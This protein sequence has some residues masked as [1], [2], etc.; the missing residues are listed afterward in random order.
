MHVGVSTF[1]PKPHTPFQWVGQ[2]SR[3]VIARHQDILRRESR[4]HGL[5][6]S[7]NEY[8]SSEV[9][10]VLSRGDRRI[11]NVIQRAWEQGARFDGW[12]EC[13]RHDLWM[14]ALVKEKLDLQ[15]YTMRERPYEERLPWAHI[16]AGVS[17]QFLW[18]EWEKSLE[19]GTTDDCRYGQCG[20]CGTD[21]RACKDA[22]RIRKSIRL[23]LKRERTVTAS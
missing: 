16:D 22:H 23:E 6:I 1:V 2:E 18:A 17:L 3:D 8:D 13:F 4:M 20:R 7:W 10:A 12:R 5:K 11:G 21:P 15:W 9:E 19:A 14:A